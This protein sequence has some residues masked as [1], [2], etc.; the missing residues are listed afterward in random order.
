M[1][2]PTPERRQVFLEAMEKYSDMVT[3]ICL[4]RMRNYHDAEDCYQ[5]VFLKLYSSD[6]LDE[7]AEHIKAWLI[8]VAINEC[9][10]TGRRF[11]RRNVVCSEEIFSAIENPKQN[12]LIREVFE[13]PEI[14]RDVIY[15]HYYEGYSAEELSQ[16]LSR[17]V[18][19]IKSQLHRGR[20]LLKQEMEGIYYEPERI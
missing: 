7:S 13:L 9:R 8:T 14:Y 12:G 2:N 20:K 19:T 4:L 1:E 11:W 10:D 18:N 17:S 5:N 15:L 3:R 6:V 16:I